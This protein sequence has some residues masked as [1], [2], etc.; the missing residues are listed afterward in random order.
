MKQF[1]YGGCS[2]NKKANNGLIKI[3]QLHPH[4]ITDRFLETATLR[5]Q[6]AEGPQITA[7]H[8]NTD[9]KKIGFHCMLFHISAFVLKGDLKIC[10]KKKKAFNLKEVFVDTSIPK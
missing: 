5:K 4:F 6:H 9:K 7:F 10:Q 2:I 8:Y 3:L 1:L